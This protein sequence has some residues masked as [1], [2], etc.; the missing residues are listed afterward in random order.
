M[1]RWF[2]ALL[3]FV[4]IAL[5]ARLAL[6]PDLVVFGTSAIALVP[7]AGL[8]GKATEELSEHIGGRMGALLNATFGNAA[9][10]IIT[11]FA[12]QRG[13][14]TLA[15][16]SITGSIIGNTLLVLG[17]S[18][19]AGGL[20]RG[21]QRFD[22]RDTSLNAAMMLLAI[23]GLYLPAV[24]SLSGQAHTIVEELSLLD[25][26]VLIATYL[27]YLV[28]TVLQGNPAS[29][30]ASPDPAESAEDLDLETA[31][32]VDK[33]PWGLKK[34]LAVLTA[35]TVGHRRGDRRQRGRAFQCRT[36]GHE[37]PPGDY[38]RDRRRLKHAGR[39]IRRSGARVSELAPR[40]SNGPRIYAA[41]AR[42]PGSFRGS[43][44]L[45]QHRRRDELAGRRAASRCV[46]DCRVRVLSAA[47]SAR[48]SQTSVTE[49][50]SC[51][52]CRS[53]AGPSTLISD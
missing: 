8:I 16:A 49:L 30:D 52:L 24:F 43:F 7:L 4:P 36:D 22:P 37:G 29:S 14:L 3:I 31:P 50:R 39:S 51:R 41:G 11:A 25:A 15:K 9:E 10:L 48:L 19:L 47:G 40:A 53:T 17:L 32:D 2:F 21:N 5:G 34:S 27:A 6:L 12:I 44:F 38:I 13:L 23:A 35:A 20:K 46:P 33:A 18:L 26:A 42:C 1:P 28:Y 45:H